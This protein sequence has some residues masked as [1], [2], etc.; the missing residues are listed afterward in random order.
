MDGFFPSTLVDRFT[1]PTIPIAIRKL[2]IFGSVTATMFIDVVTYVKKLGEIF[3][4][5][6]HII[7][8][9]QCVKRR[10]KSPLL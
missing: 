8:K 10:E 5:M 7:E 6:Q 2:F 3:L 9:C 1:D 4:G